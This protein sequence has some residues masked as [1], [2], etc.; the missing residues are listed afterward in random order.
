MT[1]VACVPTTLLPGARTGVLVGPGVV[2]LS[3]QTCSKMH[4]KTIFYDRL[5]RLKDPRKYST[6]T[7]PA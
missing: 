5:L 1:P 7:L 4:A 3:C 6:V 2:E